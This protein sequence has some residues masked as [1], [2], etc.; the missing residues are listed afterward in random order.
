MVIRIGVFTGY[1]ERLEEI[2]A[3]AAYW[4][5]REQSGRMRESERMELREWLDAS[6]AHALEYQL[7]DSLY[8]SD[9][10]SAAL[11]LSER[12]SVSRDRGRIAAPLRALRD[13]IG[14]MGL[15]PVAALALSLLLVMAVAM[16]LAPEHL[17]GPMAPNGL[18][19]G[20]MLRTEPGE[21][22]VVQLP[23]GSRI[24]LNGDSEAEIRFTANRRQIALRRGDALFTVAHDVQRPF[25]VATG[26]ANIRVV[27]TQFL[28]REFPATTSVDVFQGTVEIR[29]PHAETAMMRVT[30]GSR[31]TVGDTVVLDR[32]GARSANDWRAGWVDE[33]AV[34]LSDLAEMVERRTGDAIRVDP[35]LRDLR[36]SGR[37]KITEPKKLFR[38]LS[39][40]YGFKVTD[41]DN[42]IRIYKD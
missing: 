20:N 18:A 9:E 6:P 26:R 37:F 11:S 28:I 36:V 14:S 16:A 24:D 33:E 27:G 39:T 40:T 4:V 35:A 32:L 7:T 22:M 12:H 29:A 15:A 41:E 31:V 17:F 38:M 8:A 5:A 23:D 13:G 19:D 30:R 21:R 42:I 34:T 2:N 10:L 25:Y 1:E 3:Q